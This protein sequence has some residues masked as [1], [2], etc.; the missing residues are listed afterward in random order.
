MI[1]QYCT[2]KHAHPFQVAQPISPPGNQFVTANMS[3]VKEHEHKGHQSNS[4]CLF[5]LP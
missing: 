3:T 2:A 1:M 5:T 4:Q